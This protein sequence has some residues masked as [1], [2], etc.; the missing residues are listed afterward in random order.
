[1][2]K[3]KKMRKNVLIGLMAATM[4]IMSGCEENVEYIEEYGIQD[5]ATTNNEDDEQQNQ[6]QKTSEE[7]Q[8]EE[9]F[10]NEDTSTLSND[11]IPDHLQTIINEGGAMELKVDAD[12]V[13]SG[14]SQAKVYGAMQHK[15]TDEQLIDIAKRLF[16]GGEY[17]VVLPYK[18]WDKESLIKEQQKYEEMEEEATKEDKSL[19][20]EILFNIEEAMTREEREKNWSEEIRLD[21]SKL[22]KA[23]GENV[24]SRQTKKDYMNDELIEHDVYFSRIQGKING[25]EYEL[26]YE[27]SEGI[28]E[29]TTLKLI[30][31]F[32]TSIA[33]GMMLNKEDMTN[34]CD[35]KSIENKAKEILSKLDGSDFE[36]SNSEDRICISLETEDKW[37]DGVSLH[38]SY[39]M[40][41][42]LPSLTENLPLS[43]RSKDGRV[44]MDWIYENCADIEM[45]AN[46]DVV[47]LEIQYCFDIESP[48][49]EHAELLPLSKIFNYAEQYCAGID[50]NDQRW[51]TPTIEQIRL[52]YLPVREENQY[53]YLPFW[54]FV[55][56]SQTARINNNPYW[57]VFGVNAIDGSVINYTY[58]GLH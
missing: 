36:L 11:K 51:T 57:G 41:D 1:M 54:V 56:S 15:M 21:V 29:K 44:E 37:Y 34:S 26:S 50:V 30:P 33:G 10:K 28:F 17:K 43:V 42:L 9:A 22:A 12:I 3:D 19:N 18:Y 45:D 58:N 55:A 52:T 48:M 5:T 16:D 23:E 31:L 53:S 27:M 46:G 40:P 38:Y 39:K 7:E 20:W 13:A 14:L 24:I 6:I 32:P 25:K 4:L 2:R 47:E 8:F 49:S 35:Q